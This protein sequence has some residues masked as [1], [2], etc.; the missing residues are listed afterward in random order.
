M[1]TVQIW[2]SQSPEYKLNETI[3]F[4]WSKKLYHRLT[5]N[6]VLLAGASYYILYIWKSPRTWIAGKAHCPIFDSLLKPNTWG[7][8]GQSNTFWVENQ[9]VNDNIMMDN[10][11]PKP[12]LEAVVPDTR[13][14]IW[15][16]VLYIVL[17][18]EKRTS[19]YEPPKW[20]SYQIPCFLQKSTY[21]IDLH[22]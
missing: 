11:I 22:T 3:V 15:T 12:T 2:S 1:K 21:Y 7:G 4:I 6:S 20:T 14:W 5:R 17:K 9:L 16:T 8:G 18:S 10:T 13:L 19:I